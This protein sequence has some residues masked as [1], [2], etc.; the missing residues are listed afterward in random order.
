MNALRTFLLLPLF[1][2]LLM[3]T[4]NAFADELPPNYT[5]YEMRTYYAH[6]GKLDELH[7]RFRDHTLKLFTQA[8]MQNVI[9]LSPVE[10]DDNSM[11]YLL[12]YHSRDQRKAAW[13][14]FLDNPEWK[15]A[16]KASTAEGKLVKKIESVFYEPT[17]YSPQYSQAFSGVKKDP[18]RLFERRTY[19]TN[20]GKLPNLDARFRDHTCGLFKKH[21]IE[22]VIYLHPMK[23]Q[24]GHGS[25]LTYFIAHKD[26]ATRDASFDGFRK[27]ADWKS[28]REASEKDG[29]ILVKDGVQHRFFT[30]TD[31]S[32]IQ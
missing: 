20:E 4:P 21:G 31:Y 12:G 25:T 1:S 28:A 13:K 8:G 17:D 9:Y 27:D 14:T 11:S 10:N 24:P 2:S 15:A 26:Q 30:P 7:K 3:T 16:Y 22:N 5:V 29:K 23:G 6:E 32:P 18:A 19:T